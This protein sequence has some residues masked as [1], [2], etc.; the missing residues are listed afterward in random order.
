M[1]ELLV[2]SEHGGIAGHISGGVADDHAK[3]FAAIARG[4]DR[5]RI[6]RRDCAGDS[7]AVFLPLVSERHSAAGSDAEGGGLTGGYSLIR[8]LRSD[9]GSNRPVPIYGTSAGVAATPRERTRNEND[10]D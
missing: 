8:R 9:I 3:H 5:R 4:G 6:A 1:A 10:C 7:G 2:T